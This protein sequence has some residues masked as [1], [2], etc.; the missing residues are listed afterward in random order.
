MSWERTLKTLQDLRVGKDLQHIQTLES[1]VTTAWG[2]KWDEEWISRDIT[3][4]FF[5]ANRDK[6]DEILVEVEGTAVT[7]SA[8]EEFDI[9]RLFYLGS[10]KDDDNIG[11]YGEGFKVAVT[12]L[13]RDQGVEPIA[14]TKDTV[15]YMRISDEAVAGSDDMFPVVYDFFRSSEDC[16]GSR[17][18]LRGCSKKL[19]AALKSGLTHFFHERNSLLG[20][21][22]WTSYDGNFMIFDSTDN[23]GHIFYR[24]LRRGAIPGVPVVLV[25]NKIYKQIERYTEQDRD[26]KAFG[27]E[28]M[29]K[30]SNVFARSALKWGQRGQRII[31]EAA[32]NVWARGHPLLSQIA[33]HNGGTWQRSGWRKEVADEV[34]GD[35]YYA[36]SRRDYSSSDA[37][38]VRWKAIEKEWR[39]QGREE[40]QQ[41]FARFGVMS[42]ESLLKEQAEKA[43]QES[44]TAETREPT[45][46][47]M[48]VI[49]LLAKTMQEFAASTAMILDTKRVNY[50][51]ASTEVLRGQLRKDRSYRSYEVFFAEK[52]FEYDFAEVLAVFLHEHAHIF[53]RDGSR[54]FTD[55]LTEIVETIVRDRAEL[56]KY[57]KEYDKARKKVLRERKSS[58]SRRA[59]TDFQGRIDSMSKDQLQRL[60]KRVPPAVLRRLLSDESSK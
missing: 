38:E 48:G 55:A 36:R 35:K 33:R 27:D 2:V 59:K 44:K 15:L 41:Y 34:F 4:N 47:E 58:A 18:I 60:V 17:L 16:H 5:D 26:R 31:V 23:D 19:I 40:L 28:L 12:C 51:V 11:E 50:I 54:D 21:K 25:I 45:L 7:I 39:N 29:D 24:N 9:N 32:R 14:V 52:E 42:A 10:D 43:L 49:R 13:L 6:L 30:F 1:S 53:G 57:E 3:Q 56:D 20:P 37:D 22:R 46:A 8:P